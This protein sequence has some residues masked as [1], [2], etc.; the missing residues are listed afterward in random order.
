[1]KVLLI[2][3]NCKTSSTGKIVYDLYSFLNGNGDEAA[4]CYGR[5]D[6]VDE[7]NIFKFG[8]DW[9][10]YLHALLTRV[11]GYTG[12]FSFFS[13]RRLIRFIQRFRP[14]VVHIHELHAYFVNIKP[15]INYL[16][17]KHIRT[18][19]TLHCEFAYTG[20]CGHSVDCEQWKTECKKCPRLH[21]YVSTLWFDHTEYMFKQKKAAFV[22]FKE[23]VIST[24]SQWLSNRVAQS[25]LKNHPSYLIRNGV[26]TSVFYP[27]NT[28]ALKN[29]YVVGNKKVILAL[30]PN[31]ASKEKGGKFVI[32]LAKELIGQDVIILLVGV[33]EDRINVPENVIIEHRIFDKDLIAQY[34][35][36]AD[37]FVI[38]SERENFP[39]TCIEAQCC[40]TQICGFDTGG[41]KE[42]ALSN[43]AT[44]VPYGDISALSLVAMKL[45]RNSTTEL[46][47]QLSDTARYYYSNKMMCD[48][49]RKLY[50]ESI[51]GK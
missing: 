21:A 40:G 31:L 38:C 14:D 34:Y 12:C 4:I 20:K 16:K 6:K 44:F 26:D 33:D 8:L 5:G 29:K 22:D 27:R 11:T 32:E 3:V 7:K 24:P 23:L 19:M 48:E 46:R 28:S 1:M 37:I 47:T 18:V 9:E 41:S 39:T 13:T 15:L 30:A 51:V 2:D 10:T 25:L 42:V 49:Y 45:M 36:L 43:D 35:S 17:K 50:K